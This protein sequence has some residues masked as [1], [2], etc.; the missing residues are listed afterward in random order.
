MMVAAPSKLSLRCFG[1]AIVFVVLTVSMQELGESET[2]MRALEF[3]LKVRSALQV[4]NRDR[5]TA[6]CM[7]CRCWLIS[8]AIKAAR[9]CHSQLF[10]LRSFAIHNVA[11]VLLTDVFAC[12]ICVHVSTGT[13]WEAE[14]LCSS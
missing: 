7:G 13:G 5:L 11:C 8:C 10:R 12:A 6:L 14:Q 3:N 2:S 1:F 9:R 4:I